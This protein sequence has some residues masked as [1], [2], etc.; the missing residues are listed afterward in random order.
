M[1]EAMKARQQE[2]SLKTASSWGLLIIYGD[3]WIGEKI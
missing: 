3:E 1:T 2:C